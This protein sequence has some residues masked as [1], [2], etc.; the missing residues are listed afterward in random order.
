MFWFELLIFFLFGLIFGSFINAWVWRTETNRSVARGHSMCPHCQHQ[1]AW[2]D[3]IP[4]LSWI[5]LQGKCRYCKKAISVQYPLVEA[6][7]AIIFAVLFYTST[8]TGLVGWFELVILCALTVLLVAGFVYDARTMLLPEKFMLPAIGLGILF[9][10]LRLGQIGLSALVPQLI[11]LGVFMLVYWAI[12]FFSKGQ[13][14]G[15]GDLRLAAIM[16]LVLTPK[17]LVVGVL[18]AY[19]I[20]A[21]WGVYLIV[22]K[23]KTKK[24]RIAF[25][26]FLIIGFY[27]GLFFGT[28]IA[29]WYLGFI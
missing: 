2:Y 26:P 17:Q 10:L 3:L 13:W 25:G 18:A 28:A 8:P 5:V 11:A 27:I 6:I 15:A 22:S 12:W 19:F 9:I 21:A 16:G 20:G 29:N 14:L 24:A 4:V 23:G 7:T 1:L